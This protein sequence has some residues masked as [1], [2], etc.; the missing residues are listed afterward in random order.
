ME[1]R[2]LGPLEVVGVDGPLPLGGAKQRALL[3]LL[4]L[5]DNEVVSRTRLIDDLWGDTPPE[6]AVQS[7][8]VYV[9]RLR[10]V[11]PEATL[12]TRGQAY[13]LEVDPEQIDLRRFERLVREARDAEPQRASV[14]LRTALDL[15]RGEALAEF[16]GEPFAQIE[17]GRLDDLRVA[18]LAERIE[19]DLALGRHND[20]IGEL[21]ALSAAHPHREALPEHLMLALYR[22]GRQADAL[23]VY[24]RARE[25]LDELGLQ[26]GPGLQRL[27]LQIL[28]HDGALDLP[29]SPSAEPAAAPP[30]EHRQV[31]VLFV[32]L[33]T[34]NE[35]EDDPD[36][37]A[38]L[39]DRLHAEATAEIEAAGGAVEKGLVG[40]LLATFASEPG[41]D[42]HAVR[43]ARAAAA[44]RDRLARAFGKG[45]VLRV[46]LESGEVVLGRPGSPAMGAPVAAAADLVRWARPADIVVGDR[47][48][49]SVEAAFTLRKHER[50]HTLVAPRRPIGVRK[51]VTILFADLVDS[52]RLG[53]Q[54][55]PEAH[56]SLVDVY[57]SEM[58]SAGERHGGI[59][60]KFI[61][62]AVV[63]IFGVPAVHEDD[64]VRAVRAAAEMRDSLARLNEGFEQSW[65]LRLAGRIGIN[66]GEVVAGDHRDGDLIVTGHPVTMAERLEGGAPAGEILIGE[67]T[68]RL[69]RDAVV[70]EPV[71]LVVKGGRTVAAM[72]LVDV[73]RDAPGRARRFDSP[74]VGRD[75]E[76]EALHDAFA[77]VVRDRACHL[78]TVHGDAGVG[79]SRLVQEFVG[80]LGGEATVA[81][82]RCLSYGEGITYWPLAEVVQAI[83]RGGRAA[84]AEPT[85][86]SIAALLAGDD[87]AD[88]VADLILDAVGVGSRGVAVA[89]E[90]PWAVRKLFEALARRRPLVVVLDDLQWAEPTFVDL[91]DHVADLSRDAPIL[92]LCLARSELFARYAT[93]G[94]GKLNAT[95]MQLRALDD[96]ASRR[97]IANLVRHAPLPPAVETQIVRAAGGNPLFA[98]ELWADVVDAKLLA[99]EHGAWVSAAELGDRLIPQSI[100]ALLAARLDGLPEDERDLITCASVE[101]TLFHRS[102]IGEL[103]PHVP[104][105]QLERTI[106]TL[107]GRDL[108]RPAAAAVEGD[109]VYAF[110]HILIRDAAYESLTKHTR[111]ELHERFAAWAERTA[112]T[113]VRDF[114]EIIG[115]H[116]EQAYRCRVDL[117]PAAPDLGRLAGRASEWLAGAGRKARARSD[118]PAAIGLLSRAVSLV[119][120]DEARRAALLPELG[121]SLTEA[122]RLEE[123]GAVLTSAARAAADAHDEGAE[124]RAL[125]QRQFLRL[126]RVAEGGI[127]E[128]ARA[129]AHVVPI[130]E[131]LDDHAGLCGARRLEAWLHWNEAHAAAAGEAW[132][133]AAEEA[134]LAH[135][136]QARA[137]ILTWVASSLWFGPTPVADGIPRCEEIH[138][139][140]KGHLEAEALTLRHLAG[141]H[142]LNG[143]FA[144]ARALLATSN[145]VFDDLGPT[146]NAA[147][148]H[149][150]AVVDFLADDPAAAEGSLRTGFETLT[151]M[152]EQSCLSTTAA[153]L[154]HAVLAQG[155]EDE[156]EALV[157]QSA[158]L[159]EP[160]DLLTQVLWRG[161]KARILARRGRVDEAEALA[162]EAVSL[163]ERTDFLVHHGDALVDLAYILRDSGREEEAARTATGGLQ[164]HEQ[165][166]NVVTA[167]KIRSAF[168]VLV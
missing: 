121:A 44:T 119:G 155:R 34:T 115:Y 154:A 1:Y 141:L 110:R 168:S 76:L 53:E 159:A 145:A 69:V 113:R 102:A 96:E 98:E 122:G 74:L 78:L 11:L 73:R 58:R 64:A 90:T 133:R 114:G 163:A 32:A 131:R 88:L 79:K 61:G 46:G 97:L 134:A 23:E 146:L 10:S 54:L 29:A 112:S 94:G 83:L 150:E 13:M 105:A 41:Q 140:V 165:K 27:Q 45:L 4:L 108:I 132:E 26:P 118:L 156:A 9:S 151:E 18:A 157:V 22:A 84:D 43:A 123:A 28:N 148:S 158:E 31:T 85:R 33:A 99:W 72:R 60:E 104:D 24:A 164:L 125:V 42:D 106:A 86:A 21:E 35:A 161:A 142:A 5:N 135:D 55:D 68:Y 17:A 160:G 136:G 107:V 87:K 153:F 36:E 37:T 116:L 62:D 75:R 149:N 56:R 6:S 16:A 49:P 12:L 65:G 63:A 15:W 30:P 91:V 152:K 100:H 144:R 92:L 93:W 167:R 130:F 7:V 2:V 128:A 124:A 80:E 126:R 52:T 3:A 101:G 111:A 51:T 143:D 103:A 71:D 120:R 57:F 19:T 59:V 127:E 48:A 8:H 166:G 139:Q 162:R 117:A 129:V 109:E 147:T 38:A 95:S 25:T 77:S 137:E 67:A 81:H 66:T 82:G 138:A 20:V 14:L 39:F 40:A 47:A 50:G 70:A 89:E